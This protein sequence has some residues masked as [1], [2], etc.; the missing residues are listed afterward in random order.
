[1]IGDDKISAAAFS[2]PLRTLTADGPIEGVGFDVVDSE[3][4]GVRPPFTEPSRAFS[5]SR[6]GYGGGRKRNR[7]QGR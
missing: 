4:E 1:M 5:D 2:P 7:W 3:F 6:A